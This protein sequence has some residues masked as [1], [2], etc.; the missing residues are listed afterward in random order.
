MTLVDHALLIVAL[1]ANF[2]FH[3]WVM[4]A[5]VSTTTPTVIITLSGRCIAL[6]YI[7]WVVDDLID[8][9]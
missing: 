6:L 3:K 9:I 1:K 8:Q 5:T 2:E 4:V 7:V